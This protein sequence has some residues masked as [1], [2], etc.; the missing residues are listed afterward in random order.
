MSEIQYIAGQEVGLIDGKVPASKE[1]W[2]L[3]VAFTRYKLEY[4]YQVPFMGGR[5][6]RGGMVVDFIV[7]NP[8]PIP[9]EMMGE[10]WHSG[11]LGAGDRLRLAIL[12]NIFDREPVEIWDY[13]VPTQDAADQVVRREFLG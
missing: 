6:V 11:A 3:A 13:E 10:Y 8:F 4:D 7:S 9:V 12:M 5:S 1:E 2:R